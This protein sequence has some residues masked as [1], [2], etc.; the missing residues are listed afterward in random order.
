MNRILISNKTTTLDILSTLLGRLFSS[1]LLVFL[2]L[3]FFPLL[4]NLLI[5]I[6]LFIIFFFTLEFTFKGFK[7]YKSKNVSIEGDN[8]IVKDYFTTKKEIII[9]ISQIVNLVK[10]SKNLYRIDFKE[11]NLFGKSIYYYS[12]SKNLINLF[13]NPRSFSEESSLLL[14]EIKERNLH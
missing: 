2:F 8:I 4:D 10:V 1:F 13:I 9:N 12:S 5:R 3:S 6:V 14:N 11:N 7:I